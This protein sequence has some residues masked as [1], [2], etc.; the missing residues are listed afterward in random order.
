MLMDVRE[1]EET[2]RPRTPQF[3]VTLN[4]RCGRFCFFCRPSREAVATTKNTELHPV[5]LLAVAHEVRAQGVDSIKLTG[6]DPALYG[7]DNRLRRR[8]LPS[9]LQ[10]TPA[11]RIFPP[12]GRNLQPHTVQPRG[13]RLR[14]GLA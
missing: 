8:Q 2:T 13:R 12:R 4:S 9:P 10:Q 11:Y 5:Q 6:G 7:R 1:H 14:G 3:R